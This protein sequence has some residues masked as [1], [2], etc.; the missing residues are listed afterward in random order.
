MC[1]P[2]FY[3]IEYEIN[4]WMD[5]RQGADPQIAERQ[6]TALRA[7]IEEAGAATSLLPAVEGLPDMVFTANTALIFR[8]RAILAN[9]R[10]AE[11]QGE[12]RHS[13]TWL[14]ANGFTVESAP[15]DISFE[16]AGDAL[17]CGETLFA[18]YRIRSDAAGHQRI[19]GSIGVRV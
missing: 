3:G 8:D 7:A 12:V 1:P 18:G 14:A 17:F 10:H 9:F 2:E 16:G 6:W 19:A 4:P 5:R 15:E 13:K 11:R